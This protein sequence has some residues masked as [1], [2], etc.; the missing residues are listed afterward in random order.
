MVCRFVMALHVP[1]TCGS[2]TYFHYYSRTVADDSFSFRTAP[3]CHRCYEDGDFGD[4]AAYYMSSYYFC[5]STAMVCHHILLTLMSHSTLHIFSY[6]ATRMC[7]WKFCYG[8]RACM[9]VVRRRQR[10]QLRRGCTTM[11]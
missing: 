7:E 6:L 10:S 3:N 2:F 1:M 5:F 4:N 11:D 9:C 8:F